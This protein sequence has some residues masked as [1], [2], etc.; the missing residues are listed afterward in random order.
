MTQLLGAAPTD[1]KLQLR[2]GN[3]SE[4][5]PRAHLTPWHAGS[6]EVLFSTK[7]QLYQIWIYF[8]TAKYNRFPV[9]LITSKHIMYIQLTSPL[10][11]SQF[12]D[13]IGIIFQDFSSLQQNKTKPNE[14]NRKK[15]AS[16]KE[17][18]TNVCIWWQR[19]LW[20]K[21]CVTGK[22]PNLKLHGIIQWTDSKDRMSV[23]CCCHWTPH[24]NMAHWRLLLY[25]D[26][27]ETIRD[28]VSTCKRVPTEGCCCTK[29]WWILKVVKWSER[30]QKRPTVC[31]VSVTKRK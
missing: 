6:V 1:R 14:S 5:L 30:P 17:K 13:W 31:L 21:R 27:L 3:P 19:I 9:L 7:V 23:F 4:I 11:H 25:P 16:R 2:T 12:L 8:F 20:G 22:S 24:Q 28:C 18:R 10:S 26:C 15:K 29:Y